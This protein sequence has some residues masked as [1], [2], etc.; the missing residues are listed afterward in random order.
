MIL[1]KSVMSSLPIYYLSL[2]KI[3]VGV[4]KEIEKMQSPCLWGGLDLRRK[5]H[6]AKWDLV[7]KNK[8]VGGLGVR[9][10]RIMNEY[11]LLKWW[12]RFG[13]ENHSL[14]KE[15]ICRKYDIGGCRW[16][17][18]LDGEGSKIWSDIGN[19]SLSNPNLHNLYLN[20]TL[21]A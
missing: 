5:V 15:M 12:W 7:T 17:P 19:L 6:L 1:I 20:N 18:S 16:F 8:Q 4:A 13:V 9:R 21:I 11:L 2:F 10:I 14:W 3:P